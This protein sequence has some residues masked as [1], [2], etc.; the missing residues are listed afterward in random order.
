MRNYKTNFTEVDKIL[1]E[2]KRERNKTYFFT[3]VALYHVPYAI[4]IAYFL[5]LFVLL[6]CLIILFHAPPSLPLICVFAAFSI[7]L[8]LFLLKFSV[9]FMFFF[10][11]CSLYDK[12]TLSLCTRHPRA[13]SDLI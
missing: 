7:C 11:P 6:L 5:Y 4:R 13:H 3:A 10:C 2:L 12:K 8:K 9:P 1:F